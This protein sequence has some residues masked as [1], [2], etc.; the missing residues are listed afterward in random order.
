MTPPAGRVT[1]QVVLR[2]AD[3]NPHYKRAIMSAQY[4]RATRLRAKAMKI[5]AELPRV[6]RLPAPNSADHSTSRWIELIE[7]VATPGR[8]RAILYDALTS[9]DQ[10]MRSSDRAGRPP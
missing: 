1:A 2:R 6:P 8:D 4:D 9:F 5:R 3:A 7:Q 10:S